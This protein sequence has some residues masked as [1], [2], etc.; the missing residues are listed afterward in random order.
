MY[1]SRRYKLVASESYIDF[2]VRRVHLHHIHTVRGEFLGISLQEGLP[3]HGRRSHIVGKEGVG[4]IVGSITGAVN[5]ISECSFDNTRTSES[6]DTKDFRLAVKNKYVGGIVGNAQKNSDQEGLELHIDNCSS[7]GTIGDGQDAAGNTGGIIGRVKNETT[8]YK[9]YINNCYFKGYIV[10]TGQY[11][12]GILG[13]LDNG[14]GYCSINNCYS[15]PIFVYGG[16]TLDARKAD[17]EREDVQ[18]YAH[19]NSNPIIGRAVLN[20]EVGLYECKNNYGTWEEYYSASAGSTGFCFQAFYGVNWQP[21]EAFFKNVLDWDTD[22]IWQWN[23]ETSTIT[24][25]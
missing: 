9:T 23:D 22:S 4:G 3:I 16:V 17:V 14:S 18:T 24:L 5:Y 25:R 13:D 21:K 6:E 15:E 12:A 20:A 7:I 10:S 2:A 11:N 8:G 19:K 1:H